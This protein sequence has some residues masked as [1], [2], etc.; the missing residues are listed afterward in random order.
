MHSLT[1]ALSGISLLAVLLGLCLTGT[2]RADEHAKNT[3]PPT[4]ADEVTYTGRIRAVVEEKCNGCH[5]GEA[6]E[7]KEFKKDKEGYK[8]KSLGPKMDT[9]TYLISFVAWPDTGALMRRLDDGLNGKDGK[10]GNMYQ[11]LGD[12]AEE[13]QKNLALF[14]SWVGNWSVKRWA[15]TTK[16]EIEAMTVKY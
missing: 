15:E 4:G 9:Y 1:R 13:Q 10:P 11:Y 2:A 12:S 16:E 14:K 5:G 8:A 3:N 6:P 7:H